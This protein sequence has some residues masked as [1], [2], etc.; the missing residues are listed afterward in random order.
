MS[1]TDVLQAAIQIERD[2]AAFY[3]EAAGY[4]TAEPERQLMLR[5]A[6]MEDRHAAVFSCMKPPAGGGEK[7]DEAAVALMRSL[8]DSVVFSAAEVSPMRLAQEQDVPGILRK[9]LGLEK[10]SVV[11]YAALQD[12]LRDPADQEAVAEVIREELGHITLLSAE[13]ES[14]QRRK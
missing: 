12:M 3:R 4:M 6:A 2:G 10:D 1:K 14:L 11:F 7:A 8:A 5:L 13:L 9:A